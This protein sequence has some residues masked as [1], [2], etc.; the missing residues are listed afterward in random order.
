MNNKCIIFMVLCLER[1]LRHFCLIIIYITHCF[2]SPYQFETKDVSL[3]GVMKKVQLT[4]QN[5]Y[6]S[7]AISFEAL[8]T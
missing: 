8:T 6:R 1:K 5:S 2:S 3:S 4:L 7:V